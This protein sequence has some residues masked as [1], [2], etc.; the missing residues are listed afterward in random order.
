MVSKNVL[1]AQDALALLG[2]RTC[3]ESDVPGVKE[4]CVKS[5]VVGDG[6]PPCRQIFISAKLCFSIHI[7]LSFNWPYYHFLIKTASPGLH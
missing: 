2:G 1:E 4:H 6:R 5:G 7:L 3:L